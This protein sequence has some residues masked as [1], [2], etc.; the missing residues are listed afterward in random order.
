MAWASLQHNGG[1][2]NEHLESYEEVI[3]PFI[4]WR[5][6]LFTVTFAACSLLR[7]SQCPDRIQEKENRLFLLVGGVARF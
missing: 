2:W 4:T 6:K 7:Q 1:P 3:M 5:L